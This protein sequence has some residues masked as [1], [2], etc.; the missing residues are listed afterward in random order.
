[1]DA[2]DEN[3]ELGLRTVASRAN[4]PYSEQA[5]RNG[6]VRARVGPKVHTG[7][8]RTGCAQYVPLSGTRFMQMV[9][10][11]LLHRFMWEFA[12][13]QL[14]QKAHEASTIVD[15]DDERPILLHLSDLQ[16][17]IPLE[18]FCQVRTLRKFPPDDVRSGCA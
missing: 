1:M 2:A 9:R 10:A 11:G 14:V 15:V 5:V 7:A 17:A 4:D 18:L 3:Q 8:L 16:L 13:K 6:F 12:M